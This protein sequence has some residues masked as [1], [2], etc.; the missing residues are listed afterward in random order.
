M[1]PLLGPE[2]SLA[3]INAPGLC[4]VA[5][6]SDAIDGLQLAV[7]RA[8]DRA[9][10]LFTSHAFHSAMMEPAVA[11]FT[12]RVRRVALQPPSIPFISNV[13]GDWI[14][15]AQATDPLTGPGTCAARCASAMGSRGFCRVK[16]RS[17]SKLARGKLCDAGT[18]ASGERLRPRHSQLG[19][20]PE[21]DVAGHAGLINRR[22][23]AMAGRCPHRLESAA[24]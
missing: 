15:P 12:E 23:A 2:L 22:G 7:D 14:T 3:V 19:T 9:R 4:V 18:S 8:G 13:T 1:A 10:R 21:P 24:R 20:P 11:P 16:T 17:S 6:P 5:G